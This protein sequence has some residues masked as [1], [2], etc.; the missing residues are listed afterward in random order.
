MPG[1]QG[2]NRRE[3]NLLTFRHRVIRVGGGV[4][5]GQLKCDFALVAN[6]LNGNSFLGAVRTEW[7]RRSREGW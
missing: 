1:P 3:D 2:S 7:S 5:D 4:F 6:D